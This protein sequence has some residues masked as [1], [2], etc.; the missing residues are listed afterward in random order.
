MDAKS[1]RLAEEPSRRA[2][3]RDEP[4]A[5]TEPVT[6]DRPDQGKSDQQAER[7]SSGAMLVPVA[8]LLLRPAEGRAPAGAHRGV[9]SSESRWSK[10][11]WVERADQ[12]SEGL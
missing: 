6:K 2:E 12:V 8:F 4:T 1:A 11:R 7:E 5:R 9:A 3:A 10:W